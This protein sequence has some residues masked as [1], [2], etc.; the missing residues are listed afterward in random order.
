MTA[1][2][3]RRRLAA[4]AQ[5]LRLDRPIGIFLLL[6]PTWWALWIAGDGR[7]SLQNLLVFTAGVVL[8]RS[9][10]CAI[11]DFADRD[12][13]RQVA[14]TKDRPLAS[15]LLTTRDALWLFAVLALLSFVLVLFLNLYTILLS[16][17]ALA[18]A[19]LYPFMKRWTH[20]PQVVLGAAFSWA[21]PMAF[22]A[23]Q[24]ALPPVAWLLF[25]ANLAWTVAYDTYYAMTDRAD[26]LRA[27]VKSTAILFGRH[28][29]LIIGLLQALALG[30]LAAAGLLAGLGLP[31]WCA[32]AVAAGLFLYQHRL[33]RQRE[34]AACFRAFL[35]NNWVGLAVFVG[36]YLHFM[37][38]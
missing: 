8:M 28:D 37:T 16:F 11:N 32:L 25:F 3:L 34:P 1:L 20:L 6:W 27:G 33:A 36:I 21:I 24:E 5:L 26:D 12:F 4:C 29:L 30:L 7:P 18:L 35:H 2:P 19:A 14:R 17:G 9:A 15:G 13:D 38:V 22:A 23:E 31:Y 10:G